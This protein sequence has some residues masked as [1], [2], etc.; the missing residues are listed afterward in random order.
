[1]P[2]GVVTPP[3]ITGVLHIGT[4]ISVNETY[5]LAGTGADI[6]RHLTHQHT[7]AEIAEMCGT[8]Q[9]AV[10]RWINGIN[11]VQMTRDNWANLLEAFH[12]VTYASLI[13][14]ASLNSRHPDA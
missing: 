1:M 13:T 3:T 7:Q 14:Y 5:L 2:P 9:Q 12:A 10:H 11:Q 6:V 4:G 8:Q